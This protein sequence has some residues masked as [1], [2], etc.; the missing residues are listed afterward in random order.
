MDKLI[1]RI[2]FLYKKSKEEG[3]T[4][5]EAAEQQKLRQEYIDSIKLNFKNQLQNIYLKD[6]KK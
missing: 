2:N 3:L 4:K 6:N 1:S 5:E